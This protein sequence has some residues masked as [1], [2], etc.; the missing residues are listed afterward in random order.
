MK[1]MYTT[2]IGI[3]LAICVVGHGGARVFGN[4]GS[5]LLSRNNCPA[6]GNGAWVGGVPKSPASGLVFTRRMTLKKPLRFQMVTQKKCK[7]CRGGVH[8][9]YPAVDTQ[10]EDGETVSKGVP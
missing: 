2:N 3:K 6:S 9:T 7:S 5:G 1:N 4:F 10:G 8:P